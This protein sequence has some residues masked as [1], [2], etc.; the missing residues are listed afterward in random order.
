MEVGVTVIHA[1]HDGGI[2]I[3]CRI[4]GEVETWSVKAKATPGRKHYICIPEKKSPC[5]KVLDID[6]QISDT[7]LIN[8]IK[9]RTQF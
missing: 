4:N 1:V 5:F 7:E 9:S 2:L 8:C 6:E 3:K